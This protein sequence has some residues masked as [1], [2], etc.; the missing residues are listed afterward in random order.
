LCAQPDGY[1]SDG[2][3]FKG[4]CCPCDPKAAEPQICNNQDNNL[5]CAPTLNNAKGS[6]DLDFRCELCARL[7]GVCCGVGQGPGDTVAVRPRVV[8]SH[9]VVS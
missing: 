8:L 1:A 6:L 9:V 2:T 5:V 4:N 7:G 3:E